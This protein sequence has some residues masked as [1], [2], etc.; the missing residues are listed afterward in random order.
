MATGVSKDDLFSMTKTQL[1][2]LAKDV[3]VDTTNLKKNEV[4]KS[5]LDTLFPERSPL[6]TQQDTNTQEVSGDISVQLKLA[7]I[8]LERDRFNFELERERI[9]L[10]RDRLQHSSSNNLLSQTG[11][12]PQ[13][14]F[15]TDIA[16]KLL[17]KFDPSDV[18]TYFCSFEKL[19][20]LNKW[21]NDKLCALL[22]FQ[23]TL[24]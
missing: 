24:F 17:P 4:L 9:Q 1:D 8:Q 13:T 7:Q 15:R 20:F 3:G 2:D 5:L 12:L 11:S 21:P 16:S 10:E 18:E 22:Q 14:N 19:A 6:D 23:M